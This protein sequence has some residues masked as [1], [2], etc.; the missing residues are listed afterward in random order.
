MALI[1]TKAKPM[2][3][4]LDPDSKT[5]KIESHIPKHNWHEKIF[6]RKTIVKFFEN[7]F[8]SDKYSI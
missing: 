3:S 7:C 1:K 6:N 8:F 2:K 5:E 4:K